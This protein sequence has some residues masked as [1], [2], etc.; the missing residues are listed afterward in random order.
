MSKPRKA[1]PKE[2]EM[3]FEQALGKLEEIVSEMEGDEL[4]LDSLLHR[5]QEGTQL[6]A[7]CQDKLSKA[8]VLIKKLEEQNLPSSESEDATE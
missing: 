6:A 1:A 7:L 5:Y 3:P 2:D 8:E 4:D